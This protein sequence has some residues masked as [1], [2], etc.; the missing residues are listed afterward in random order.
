[1]RRVR[2]EQNAEREPDTTFEKIGPEL[3]YPNTGVPMRLTKDFPQLEQLNDDVGPLSLR[4]S[5]KLLLHG[6]ID[7]QKFFQRPPSNCQAA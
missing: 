1:M 2:P 4:K 6:G 3:S 7:G 5:A